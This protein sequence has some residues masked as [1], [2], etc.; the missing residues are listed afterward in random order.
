M[1]MVHSRCSYKFAMIKCGSIPNPEMTKPLWRCG[2]Q[3]D[4]LQ[5][6]SRTRCSVRAEETVAAILMRPR[7]TR[8]RMLF[9]S[10]LPPPKK[11]RVRE[12]RVLSLNLGVH[13]MLGCKIYSSEILTLYSKG[14]LC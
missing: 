1:Q 9:L 6:R 13:F 12:G 10:A 3:A 14:T 4:D 2:Q 11:R 5:I 8:K 7:E